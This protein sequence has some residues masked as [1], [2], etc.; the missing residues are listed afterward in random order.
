MG[1]VP[2]HAAGSPRLVGIELEVKDRRHR[3]ANLD[4][5]A[6]VGDVADNA[7][8]RA[9]VAPYNA[10]ALER[11]VARCDPAIAPRP[12]AFLTFRSGTPALAPPIDDL[13]GDCI[14]W[15]IHAYY[16]RVVIAHETQR[17]VARACSLAWSDYRLC[18]FQGPLANQGNF[19]KTALDGGKG[20]RGAD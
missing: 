4:V 18:W 20:G 3:A 5:G 9:A 19:Q 1:P 12:A 11:L 10:A 16:S 2:G 13:A 6:G 7:F 14:L 15:G 17:T 8:D